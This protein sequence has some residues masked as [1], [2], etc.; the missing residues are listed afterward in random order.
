[1]IKEIEQT[2]MKYLCKRK[3][4]ATD[5]TDHL[6]YRG[7]G[8]LWRRILRAHPE[9]TIKT[10]VLGLFTKEELAIKGLYYSEI[11][12][13]VES[14]QWANLINEVGDGGDTSNTEKYKDSLSRKKNDPFRRLRKTIHNPLTKEIRRILPTESLPEGFVWGNTPGKEFGPKKGQTVVYHNGESKIYLKKG[15]DPPPGF[16]R[17]IHYEGSTK[18]REGYYNP[19][20]QEKKYLLPGEL[21]P[22]GFIKGLPPTL[23]KKVQTPFGLFNSI[24]AC[25][26]SLNITRYTIL[27]NIKDKEDWYYV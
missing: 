19:D 18:G 12:N 6:K 17:G 16:V 13:I 27:S 23:G 22:S 3:Q 15:E 24:Q 20:T 4:H 1:M 7:S 5:E 14:D 8:V 2:G 10:T 11:Y 26:I 9:Y 25:I 21:P